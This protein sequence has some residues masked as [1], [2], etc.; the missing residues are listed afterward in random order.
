M[1]IRPQR[2]SLY[3]WYPRFQSVGEC[4]LPYSTNSHFD[5]DT[6][7]FRAT[8]NWRVAELYFTIT[9]Q[10][11]LSYLVRRSFCARS[12]VLGYRVPRRKGK[13]IP[14]TWSQTDDRT[15]IL[16]FQLSPIEYISVITVAPL[17][18]TAASRRTFCWSI[19]LKEKG[20]S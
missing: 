18:N 2:K 1:F 9:A 14:T 10:R 6:C 15:L 11:M 20:N 5:T 3:R 16:I 4:I 17:S 7:H 13:V 12:S 8:T 19:L